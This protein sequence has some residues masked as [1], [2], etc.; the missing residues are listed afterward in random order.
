M[1]GKPTG[2]AKLA[3]AE[4]ES[5]LQRARQCRREREREGGGKE[6]GELRQ[7]GYGIKAKKRR[8][9]YWRVIA[10]LHHLLPRFVANKCKIR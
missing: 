9:T 3:L 8:R 6:E 10:L 5:S 7:M 1:V 4:R 2:T